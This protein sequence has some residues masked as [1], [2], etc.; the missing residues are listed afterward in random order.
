[1][2]GRT[3]GWMDGQTD[4]QMDGW[5]NGWIDGQMDG[6]MD[7]QRD[8]KSPVSTRLRPLSGPL[9]KKYRQQGWISSPG[10][11]KDLGLKY[12]SG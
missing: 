8:G 9:P 4:G 11:N 1:M 10:V 5:T 3:D 7:G 12:P 2:D 6:M